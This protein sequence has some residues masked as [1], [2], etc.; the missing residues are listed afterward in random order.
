M[1]TKFCNNLVNSSLLILLAVETIKVNPVLPLLKEVAEAEDDF[2]A[3][4]IVVVV[5]VAAAAAA[6]V[7]GKKFDA[8]V[9]E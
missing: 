7:V 4:E 3:A 1:N 6:A 5:V 8:L 9:L 2:E